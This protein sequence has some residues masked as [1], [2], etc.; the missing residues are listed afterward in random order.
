MENFNVINNLKQSNDWN[1]IWIEW[2]DKCDN[3]KSKD[4]NLIKIDDA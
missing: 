4:K 1:N 3:Y 2:K